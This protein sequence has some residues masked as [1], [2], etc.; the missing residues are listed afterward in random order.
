[1]SFDMEPINP[2]SF[3]STSSSVVSSFTES[4]SKTK[5]KATI[6][7]PTNEWIHSNSVVVPVSSLN[8]FIN[9]V[10]IIQLKVQHA[11]HVTT[12]T[13]M[14]YLHYPSNAIFRFQGYV[15]IEDK[16]RLEKD[17]RN[18][19]LRGG[20]V[21]SSYTSHHRDSYKKHEFQLTCERFTLADVKGSVFEDGYFQASGTIIQRAHQTASV[22]GS[23]RSSNRKRLPGDSRNRSESKLPTPKEQLCPFT[24]KIFLSPDS[25][26]YLSDGGTIE[27]FHCGHVFINPSHRNAP[28]SIL[29][30]EVTLFISSLQDNLVP[31]SSIIGCV[32][33]KFG[34]QIN[35]DQVRRLRKE[36]IDKLALDAIENRNLSSADR[37]IQT[38]KSIPD[39]NLI[40][41]TH[42]SNTGFVTF[43]KARKKRASESITD[44]DSVGVTPSAMEIWRRDLSIDGTEQILVSIAWCLDEEKEEFNNYPE[45][46][47]CDVTFGLNRNQRNVAL[48]AVVDGEMKVSTVL[49]ALMPSK[50]QSCFP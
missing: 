12:A 25:L 27:C 19:A 34:L 15:G 44:E 49:R 29:S 41:V 10:D 46:I 22:K 43:R 17:I 28:S 13:Y 32:K 20:T 45:Y 47:A 50:Q 48:L 35:A 5:W 8:N 23:S 7:I 16:S 1:M 18:Y 14:N 33:D 42:K 39:I 4:I 26:W 24:I 9:E 6:F 2:V 11:L 37:L 36:N 21:L 31:T 30:T 38:L 3:L 40:Y